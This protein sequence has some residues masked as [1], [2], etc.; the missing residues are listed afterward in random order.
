RGIEAR[1]PEFQQSA[2]A[3]LKI[4]DADQL[5]TLKNEDDIVVEGLVKN[6]AD[7]NVNVVMS[8][9]AI[10]ELGKRYLIKYGIFGVE[11]VNLKDLQKVSKATGARIVAST[12]ELAPTDIG[13]AAVVEQVG[14]EGRESIYIRDAK[15]SKAVTVLIRAGTQ[16]VADEIE[17]S[18]DDAVR[19]VACV[20][21][22]GKMIA[23]GGATEIEIAL[24]LREYANT[25]R[26]R[27][28]LAVNAYADAV[29]SLVK[30]LIQ[31]MGLNPLDIIADLKSAH[32]EGG[33]TKGVDV[34][35][36][37]RDMLSEGVVEALRVK[38]QMLKSATDTAKMVLRIDDV[39]ASRTKEEEKEEKPPLPAG[40]Q[41]NRLMKH[42]R[43]LS[44]RPT[45]PPPGFVP[46]AR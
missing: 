29:E 22:D 20:L 9:K 44:P 33:V 37:L 21:E 11:K 35:G 28:Q 6:L 23:G 34:R 45:G 31:N 5:K 27:E 2:A 10:D 46:T 16:Q 19:V 18:L 26:G 14:P 8:E 42:M 12:K 15:D 43:N 40:L 7:A 13:M 38:K 25:L 41:R 30:T 32:M 1:K 4:S 3:V 36:V 17:R 39:L 24:K